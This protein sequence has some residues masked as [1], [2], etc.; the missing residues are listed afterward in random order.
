M[1][2]SALVFGVIAGIL[3]LVLWL[4]GVSGTAGIGAWLFVSLAFIGVQWYIGPGLIK[5][6]TR[7]KEAK[8][9][10]YPALHAIVEKY[11]KIAGIP[12]PK[13]YVVDNPTPNAFAFGRTQ[14]SSNIAVH[15]GLLNML[16]KHEVEGV[17]AHEIG[18]IKHRDVVIMT[19]ASAL[20]V[21]LYYAVLLFGTRGDRDRGGGSWFLVFLG[22]MLAQFI[23]TLLVLWLSRQR[24]YYADAFSA[25]ATENP[26]LLMSGLA[27]ISYVQAAAQPQRGENKSM[28]AF[29]IADPAAGERRAV[30]EIA[31]AIN[32]GDEKALKEAIER[33]KR[34]G[35]LE[36]FMTHPL[37]AKRL[38]AL[39]AIKKS[40]AA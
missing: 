3:A 22:A 18:H 38:E 14:S 5:L 40:L 25:Y 17:V 13:V 20:P 32:S 23:G 1:L 36:A 31:H 34:M 11:A 21:I 37:T 24:E 12:K 30:A 26:A 29:Y 10:E 35:I 9:S 15:S 27:K 28:K 39:L 16:G 33:E 8:Q 2:T 6:V 7:A 19:I 4:A